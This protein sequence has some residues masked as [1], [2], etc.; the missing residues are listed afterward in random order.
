MRHRMSAGSGCRLGGGI[1]AGTCSDRKVKSGG[2]QR[3][4]QQFAS[5]LYRV[6]FVRGSYGAPFLRTPRPD[7]GE[8]VS[9]RGGKIYGKRKL[10]Q[11]TAQEQESRDRTYG[12]CESGKEQKENRSGG[13][14]IVSFRGASGSYLP[15]YRRVQHGEIPGGK[16]LRRL[17]RGKHGLFPLPRRQ[18]GFRHI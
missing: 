9:R 5:D 17:Y 6:R 1:P 3:P 7:G 10:F 16:N 11:K 14:I 18:A 8:G 13:G 2:N 15:V 4:G 12:S